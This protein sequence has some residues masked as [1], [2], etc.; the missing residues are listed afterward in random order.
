MTESCKVVFTDDSNTEAKCR[1]LT[2]TQLP[3][4]NYSIEDFDEFIGHYL[5]NNFTYTVFNA[6]RNDLHKTDKVIK[7]IRHIGQNYG[8]VFDKLKAYFNMEDVNAIVIKFTRPDF[9]KDYTVRIA[10]NI[11]TMNIV[12]VFG[13]ENIIKIDGFNS[14]ETK[15]VSISQDLVDYISSI[16]DEVVKSGEVPVNISDF[17][18]RYIEYG[19]PLKMITKPYII[20]I[21]YTLN[22]STDILNFTSSNENDRDET[23]QN[24]NRPIW[25]K[26]IYRTASLA[27]RNSEKE[28]KNKEQADVCAKFETILEDA[29]VPGEAILILSSI[30]KTC[31]YNKYRVLFVKGMNGI[32]TTD[33]EKLYW[34]KVRKLCTRLFKVS[35]YSFD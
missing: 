31:I 29:G 32:L 16:Y 4:G 18:R 12:D 1:V 26:M 7:I 22:N 34:E 3:H 15:L 5:L 24:A 21:P 10:I 14:S 30:L 27:M 2:I 8:H 35:I 23:T 17:Y 9:D 6:I 20:D 25:E 13:E 11:P 28:F 33:Q 19:N